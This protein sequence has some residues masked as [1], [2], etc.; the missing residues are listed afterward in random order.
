MDEE[1]ILDIKQQLMDFLEL[2]EIKHIDI[3]LKSGNLVSHGL[4]SNLEFKETGFICHFDMED[5]CSF[6]HYVPYENID[7]ISATY[8][9]PRRLGE[10]DV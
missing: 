9:C 6:R 8:N 7:Y 10:S 4:D 2:E 1:T 3:R 5:G